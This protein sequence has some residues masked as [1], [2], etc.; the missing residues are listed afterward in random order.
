MCQSFHDLS[1]EVWL[2]GDR[3]R[4]FRPPINLPMHMHGPLTPMQSDPF[5]LIDFS[6][7]KLGR[8][9]EN[10]YRGHAFVLSAASW[11][12]HFGRPFG[13]RRKKG[14]VLL[15]SHGEDTFVTGDKD[16]PVVEVS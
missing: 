9:P 11:A 3:H 1:Q 2:S 7:I 10:T 5:P 6:A 14:D 8:P 15:S 4:F 13:S 12:A 16:R